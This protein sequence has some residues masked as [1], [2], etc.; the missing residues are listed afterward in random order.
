ML[1]NSRKEAFN[2]VGESAMISSFCSNEW[3]LSL[4]AR[5]LTVL[6]LIKSRNVFTK[7]SAGKE[8][9]ILMR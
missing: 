1:D 9:R 5:W 6:I 7:L 3:S 2:S 4:S 8:T